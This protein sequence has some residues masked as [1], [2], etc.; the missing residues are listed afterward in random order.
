MKTTILCVAY[1]EDRDGGNYQ[2]CVLIVDGKIAPGSWVSSDAF[3]TLTSHFDPGKYQCVF[4]DSGKE[5][6]GLYCDEDAWFCDF[7]FDNLDIFTPL[8][9]AQSRIEVRFGQ[10]ENDLWAAYLNQEVERLEGDE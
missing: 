6:G 4:V 9:L 7:L 1:T 2:Q 5:L 3:A 8:W 10:L